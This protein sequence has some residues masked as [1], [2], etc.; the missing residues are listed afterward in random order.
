MQQEWQ[1]LEPVQRRTYQEEML[2]NCSHL[3]AMGEECPS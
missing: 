1:Q 3:V 2:Q